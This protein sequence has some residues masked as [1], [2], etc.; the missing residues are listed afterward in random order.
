M[1]G[2]KVTSWSVEI[3]LFQW[4]DRLCGLQQ[5]QN[6]VADIELQQFT[7]THI[8]AVQIQNTDGSE[9]TNK[10]RDD[11][12]L[13][14]A[15]VQF[16]NVAQLLQA[17]WHHGELFATQVKKPFL[18]QS[19]LQAVLNPF[20]GHRLPLLSFGQTAVDERDADGWVTGYLRMHKR[21]GAMQ[22][23]TLNLLK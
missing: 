7:D 1:E 13:V 9:V 18:F 12:D 23:D 17:L 22:P 5:G 8:V 3:S 2:S 6:D 15:Q 11:F 19:D 16:I 21:D 4:S 20:Q 10:V 14:H